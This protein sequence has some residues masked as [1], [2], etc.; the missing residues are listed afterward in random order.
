MYVV[1]VDIV[2]KCAFCD[3]P[4]KYDFAMFTGAWVYGCQ[5]H[6]EQYRATPNLGVGQGIELKLKGPGQ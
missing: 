4:A 6:W 1:L 2:P 3:Q 5:R